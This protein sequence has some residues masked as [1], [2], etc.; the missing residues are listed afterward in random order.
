MSFRRN[1]ERKEGRDGRK[2]ARREGVGKK[3]GRIRGREGERN[4]RERKN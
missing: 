2:E 3:G 4:V 1:K